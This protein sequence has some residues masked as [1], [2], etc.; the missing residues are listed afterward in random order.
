[1]TSYKINSNHLER[2]QERAMT[3]SKEEMEAERAQALKDINHILD[4]SRPKNLQ[5]GVSSGV[6]NILQGAVGAVGVAVLLPTVGL[7]TGLKQGGI[8]GGVV[9]VTGG[10]IA[11]ALGAAALVVGGKQNIR[12]RSCCTWR[13][14]SA[15]ARRSLSSFV[16]ACTH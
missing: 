14:L 2:L 10:A 8:L 6:S 12:I 4:Q 15:K 13:V 16:V 5:Q 1:L 7:A 3:Q 11:G 9:G